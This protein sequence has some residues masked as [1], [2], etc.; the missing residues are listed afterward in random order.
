MSE[1]QIDDN[2]IDNGLYPE[3]F[4]KIDSADIQINPFQAFKTFTVL[5]GSAT[6]SILPLQGVYTDTNNLPATSVIY[7]YK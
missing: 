3:V 7:V 6:S 4:K 2:N 5:S 1:T